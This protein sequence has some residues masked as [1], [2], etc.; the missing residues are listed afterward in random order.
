MLPL[1]MYLIKRYAEA[2]KCENNSEKLTIPTTNTTY[3]LYTIR[4]HK[5]HSIFKFKHHISSLSNKNSGTIRKG[6]SN[7]SRTKIFPEVL[8]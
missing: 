7:K 4:I 5:P 2:P 1:G 6:A 8:N 3:I